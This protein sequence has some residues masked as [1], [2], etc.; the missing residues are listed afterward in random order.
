MAVK[1]VEGRQIAFPRNAKD[2]GHALGH[3]TLD[4]KVASQDRRSIGHGID[5]INVSVNYQT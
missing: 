4:Q 5:F 1:A 2:M 3:Q